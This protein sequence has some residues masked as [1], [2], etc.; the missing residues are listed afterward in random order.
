MRTFLITQVTGGRKAT[1]DT[2]WHLRKVYLRFPGEREEVVY[3][4][5]ASKFRQRFFRKR[6]HKE[7]QERENRIVALLLKSGYEEVF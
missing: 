7:L 5:K 3:K 1:V 4:V 2:D 6:I